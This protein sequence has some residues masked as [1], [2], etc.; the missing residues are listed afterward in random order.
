M[1]I[2]SLKYFATSW[3]TK[4]SVIGKSLPFLFL[5]FLQTSSFFML[6]IMYKGNLLKRPQNITRQWCRSDL[7]LHLISPEQNTAKQSHLPAQLG[8]LIAGLA[9]TSSLLTD[10][11]QQ[12]SPV[13][14]VTWQVNE[15]EYYKQGCHHNA[16][17]GTRTQHRPV[18]R[19]YWRIHSCANSD[20]SFS[21]IYQV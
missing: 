3:L 15:D 7:K 11:P 17:N 8:V 16:D 21:L 19:W 4:V 6:S 10:N 2:F 13:H 5:I 20:V 12:A 1:N 14:K 9:S 18:T